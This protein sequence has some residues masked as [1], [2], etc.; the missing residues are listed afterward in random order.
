MARQLKLQLTRREKK[1]II[2]RVYVKK[3]STTAIANSMGR[4][5]GTINYFLN[6]WRADQTL[7]RVNG[8]SI[9]DKKKLVKLVRERPNITMKQIKVELH[10]S[11]SINCI[12]TYLTKKGF[13]CTGRRMP[14][15]VEF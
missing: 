1:K 15:R 7:E 3:E 14:T 11:V 2:K 9:D 12:S 13:Q 10:S 5:R 8:L 6:K 4:S